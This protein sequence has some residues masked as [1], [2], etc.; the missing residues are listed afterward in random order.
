MRM[1][2]VTEK[3]AKF[4]KTFGHKIEKRV[5]YYASA[6]PS[7]TNG[8]TPSKRVTKHIQLTTTDV[9][10]RDP[11]GKTAKR[12]G[13]LL[14]IMENDPTKVIQRHDLVRRLTNVCHMDGS[15]A[16]AFVGD[17]IKRGTIR[18]VGD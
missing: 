2:K 6:N 8:H 17:M 16:N 14:I 9:K 3:Q 5:E 18:Y 4:L 7:F 15:L 12:W 1:R 13:N 11:K 10:F